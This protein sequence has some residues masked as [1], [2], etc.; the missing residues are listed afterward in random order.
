M[1]VLV[2]GRRNSFFNKAKTVLLEL[3]NREHDVLTEENLMWLSPK[4]G[5]V[6]EQIDGSDGQMVQIWKFGYNYRFI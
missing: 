2:Y 3:D 1:S 5:Y 4:K 6:V